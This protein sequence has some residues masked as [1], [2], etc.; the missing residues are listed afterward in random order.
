MWGQSLGRF[1]GDAKPS[2]TAIAAPRSLLGTDGDSLC[3]TA[4]DIPEAGLAVDAER[5]PWRCRTYDTSGREALFNQII[6][7]GP[8]KKKAIIGLKL[9]AFGLQRIDKKQYF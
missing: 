5:P 2:A 7:S 4:K 1:R 9:N 6:S 3:P 8:A